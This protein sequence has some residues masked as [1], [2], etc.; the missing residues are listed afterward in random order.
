MD[1]APGFTPASVD[2]APGC[3]PASMDAARG[4]TPASLD[5]SLVFEVDRSFV[6]RF[7]SIVFDFTDMIHSFFLSCSISSTLLHRPDS[8]C[9]SSIHRFLPI[10][11]FARWFFIENVML[12]V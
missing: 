5:S 12:L 11:L 2:A 8:S 10:D 4:F 9:T 7:L 6:E 1:A 3:T